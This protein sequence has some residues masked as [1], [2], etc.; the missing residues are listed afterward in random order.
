MPNVQTYRN[1]LQDGM[2]IDAL[3]DNLETFRQGMQDGTYVRSI[4]ERNAREI[5]MLNAD[6]Q[7]Y[8]RGVN[9]LGTEIM[10]YRPYSAATV[11]RKQRK[12]QP[13]SRVTLRDTGD[14]HRS[15]TVETGPESFS[16]TATDKKTQWQ[17]RRYGET[18]FGLTPD[19][20]SYVS[21]FIVYPEL[22]GIM[23]EV[24]YG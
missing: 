21:V 24:V 17:V 9:S 20:L 1:K 22:S 15:F 2:T 5:E 8:D 3:I 13:Y 18:I 4:V 23:R 16:I 12:G 19:N 11:R 6:D 7:L 14:F 10:S